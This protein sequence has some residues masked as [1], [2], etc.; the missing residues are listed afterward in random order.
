MILEPGEKVHIVERHYFS[1]DIR[2][3]VAAIPPLSS[4]RSPTCV[5]VRQLPEPLPPR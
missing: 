4:D 2:R 5:A 1:D 3:H